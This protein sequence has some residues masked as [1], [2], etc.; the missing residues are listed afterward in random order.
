VVSSAFFP[1]AGVDRSAVTVV[2]RVFLVGNQWATLAVF[3]VM[4]LALVSTLGTT[5]GHRLASVRVV[6]EDGAPVVGLPK[7]AVRT[8]LL[9]L[10][11]PAVVWDGEG[12]G[13]H[14]R[15]ATT[16][17]VRIAPRRDRA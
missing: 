9:L 1:A 10:V 4:N 14:D 2:E 7:A 17:V 15:A 13:L 5:I 12:R 11:I 16:R 6:R 8:A 3:A